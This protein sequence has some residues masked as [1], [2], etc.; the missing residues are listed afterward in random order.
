MI[1]NLPLFFPVRKCLVRG[2]APHHHILLFWKLCNKSISYTRLF[3]VLI[4]TNSMVSTHLTFIFTS[5][6]ICRSSIPSSINPLVSFCYSYSQRTSF[7]LNW[8]SSL[9][10]QIST[11]L[12]YPGSNIAFWSVSVN[13][14]HKEHRFHTAV[15]HLYQFR[16]LQIWYMLAV[17]AFWSASVTNIHKQHRFHTTV[18]HLYYFRYLI[19]W[20]ALAVL[21]FW[22]VSVTHI[23][24]EFRFTSTVVYL[25]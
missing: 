13:H 23:H 2:A 7:P 3:T 20:H 21:V 6:D 5:L 15:L 22:S 1:C 9:L 10:V 12:A 16:Y 19:I 11:N 18:L 25:Y 8:R 4:F 17:L 14:I 24:K